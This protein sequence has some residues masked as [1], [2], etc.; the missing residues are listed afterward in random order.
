MVKHTNN[1]VAVC[2]FF[3]YFKPVLFKSYSG[4]LP[5]LNESYNVHAV[6]RA[7]HNARYVMSDRYMLSQ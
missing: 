7:I 2:L 3:C 5:D 4:F 6:L 1:A